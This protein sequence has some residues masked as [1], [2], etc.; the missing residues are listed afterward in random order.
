LLNV[1]LA[2]GAPLLRIAQNN[3]ATKMWSA[4][5][6]L[7]PVMVAGGLSNLA[8][9]VYLMR[10][11]RSGCRFLVA[12]TGSHWLLAALMAVFWFGSTA[13]YGAAT[14]KLGELGTVFAWPAFMSLIVIAAVFW[15]IIT[16]EWANAGKKP[17]RMMGAGILMLIVAIVFFGLSSR[18]L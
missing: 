4:N 1:G 10:K 16:G 11:K 9:C 13:I 17:L 3:G 14:I 18:M 2:Y 15:G 7:L 12:G 6:A 5:A 8:Y